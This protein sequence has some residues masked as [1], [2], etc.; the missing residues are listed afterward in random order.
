MDLEERFKL[1]RV[2]CDAIIESKGI[3]DLELKSL[4]EA[5]GIL[6]DDKDF[7]GVISEQLNSTG[8]ISE[9]GNLLKN[10]NVSVNPFDLLVNINNVIICF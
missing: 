3:T 5:K 9:T 6:L 1:C 8:V 7:F 2:V 10:F 4:L